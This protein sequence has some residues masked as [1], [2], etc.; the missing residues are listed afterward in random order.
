PKLGALQQLTTPPPGLV[1]AEVPGLVGRLASRY[2]GHLTGWLTIAEDQPQHEN[3]IAVDQSRAD[4]LG[5]PVAVV[6]HRHSARDY[7]A[8]KALGARARQILRR[9]GAWAHYRHRVATFSHGVGTVRLGTDPRRSAL[10]A[11]CR[12]RGLD[13]LYV[14]DGSIFPTSAAVNPSLTIAANAL[15]AAR[16]LLARAARAPELRQRVAAH[17]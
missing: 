10:D 16:R 1:R 8:G 17:D 13:N 2:V 5:M 14:V 7:R 4:R 6:T 15:R 11:E 3:R 12:F 9:A